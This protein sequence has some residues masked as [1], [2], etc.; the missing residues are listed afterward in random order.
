LTINLKI[1]KLL[2]GDPKI[3]GLHS[4]FSINPLPQPNTCHLDNAVEVVRGSTHPRSCYFLT[5]AARK[6]T[7]IRCKVTGEEKENE[8]PKALLLL[9]T[10]TRN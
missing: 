4:I 6:G 8:K 2:K 10:N 1:Q 9:P 7:R 5:E 3:P